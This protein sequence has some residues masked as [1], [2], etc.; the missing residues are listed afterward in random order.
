MA[1]A[2]DQRLE[3]L[4]INTIRMLSVDAVQKANSGHPGMPMGAAGMAYVLWTEYLKHNPRDPTWPDRDRFVLS[5]GHGSM[6]LYSLLHLTG[7]DLPLEDIQRFRQLG[8][9][10]PGHPELGHTSGVELTT[11]PLGQGF[12][13]GVGMAIAEAFL[14]AHFNRPGY[15]VV[16]HYTFG[17]VSDG[18]VMEGVAAEAASLAG[19]LKLGKLIY[20]YDQNEITLAGTA[21]VAF[22]E[23]VVARFEG[24]GWQAFR[25]DGMDTNAVRDALDQARDDSERPTLIACRTH[26]GYGSPNKQDTYSAHGSPLGEDEVK[27]TK[28]NL[29]W[30]TDETFHLPDEAVRAF[31]DAIDRGS[32]AQA[33]WRLAFEGYAETHPE[34]AAEFTRV[35]SG[36]LP[37]DWD[38][39]IPTFEPG[40]QAIATRKAS[41]AVIQAF[42]PRL[43][44]FIGGSADLNP[45]TNT[46]MKGGGDFE[47]PGMAQAGDVQGTLGGG[48]NYAG[49][50]I[51]FGVREHAMGSAVNGMA[52]HGGVIPF[53]ATFLVF[54]D[55]MRPAIRLSA[56][57]NLKTIW[58]FTH[59]SVAVGE[60]GPTH[61]PVEHVMSLRLIPNLTV[62]RPADAIETAE[63]WRA[64]IEASNPVALILSRQDLAILD[65]TAAQENASR[66]GY[67]L[68]DSSGTP[69]IVLIATGSEVELSVKARDLL[70]EYGVST[71]VVSLP[72]WELFAQQD[73]EY[74]RQVLGVADGPRLTIEAGVTIGWE[75]YTGPRGRSIGLDRYGASGPG[76]EVL[77]HFGFTAERVAATALQMLGRD[78]AAD[79][80][81]P[82]RK[83]GETAGTALAGNEGH[84]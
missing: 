39:D 72:S 51:H 11:G 4:A 22:S 12:A 52:A 26:I 54:S 68:F 65:R 38:A 50:N 76:K 20:L 13:N 9:Q 15:D 6:L 63:A 53:G 5:A 55:Y 56:I 79:Q 46:G 44:T 28:E 45:S 61:E 25:I 32:Q 77:A 14:A 71:R 57:A 3:T 29:G 58:V 16:N 42:F 27:L 84:S 75:R 7:Y 17:I 59:D 82:Q 19:H 73:Q 18:D 48:W 60:D 34:P 70:T 81:E 67:V 2:I 43:S 78:D 37:D 30:P 64:A 31:R 21:N 49:R 1:V 62:I 40:G 24:L 41:E 83:G 36:E 69:D 23:D 33:A 10:T 66:G 35:M 74:Q 80:I 47:S 8:S